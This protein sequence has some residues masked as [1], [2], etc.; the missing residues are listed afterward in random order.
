MTHALEWL[1]VQLSN[2]LG[3]HTFMV[4]G[5]LAVILV[6]L[7]CGSIGSLVVGNRMAFFSDALAHCAF[8]G[9]ACA[10]V[11]IALVVGG[12]PKDETRWVIPLVMAS[13]GTIMGV[14]I[15][16]VREKTGLASDTVIGVFF[17][18]AIG[19]GALIF[20]QVKQLTGMDPEALLFGSPYFVR[21]GDLLT[22][23]ALAILTIVVLVLYSNQMI[24]AS[25]NPSLARSRRIPLRLYNYVFIVLLALVV[26]LCLQAVG[27][28]L[29]NA[30]LIVP[31]ATASNLSRNMKQMFWWTVGLSLAAGLGGLWVSNTVVVELRGVTLNPGASGSIV[32]LSVLA[33]AVSM[34]I[35]PWIRGRQTR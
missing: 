35:S 18:G 15:A 6:S 9:V 26:N 28:L 16:F 20:G 14:S 23:F 17:A 10:I 27:I 4:K 7:I 22:L 34:I 24:F 3:T 8:A 29:I 12:R 30:M 2:A 32:V 13:F 31:G 1:I 33:F 5:A 19:V 11:A 21:E 25:F